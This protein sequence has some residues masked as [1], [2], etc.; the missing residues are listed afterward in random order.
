[1]LLD[2]VPDGGHDE[3]GLLVGDAL[4]AVVVLGGE[5]EDLVDPSR[6]G[7][8]EHGATVL[9]H[10]GVV[11]LEGGVEVGHHPHEPVA[12]RAVGL[13]GRGVDPSLP[14]QKGQG[15][16]VSAWTGAGGAKEKG[17]CDPVGA[18][19]DPAAGQGVEAKLVHPVT[20]PL[21][22]FVSVFVH[23]STPWNA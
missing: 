5:D 19:D 11:A 6:R 8:G 13:E 7:L 21:C 22:A 9:D 17:R 10:E 12:A 14:G 1:M 16:V 15:R 20:S 23:W 18:D 3:A 2:A 4:P